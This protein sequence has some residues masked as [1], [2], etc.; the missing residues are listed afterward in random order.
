MA[1]VE[2]GVHTGPQDIEVNELRRVWRHCDGAGFDLITVWDH[3]YQSPYQNPQSPTY[4]AGALL[5]AMALDTTR[6]RIGCLCFGMGYRNPAVLAKSLTTIDHLSGG[7][8]TVGLGAGWLVEEH[9]AYGVDLLSVKERLNRLDEGVQV[10]RSL[11]NEERSSFEGKYYELNDATNYPRPLQGRVPII[12]GGG[13]E[14]RTMAIA[15][16]YGDG[17]N[18]A[19][20]SADAY[21]HKNHVLDQWCERLGRDPASLERSVLLHFRMSSR[22]VPPDGPQMDGAIFGPPGQ[23]IDQLG[24][25]VDARAQRI[26]LAIR[27]PVDWDALDTFIAEVMPA[28][29]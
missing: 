5:A 8:L 25:Y 12:V 20:M 26:S 2:L 13:G 11:L 7:R 14:Q 10:V 27:P 3:F 4:E 21:R 28:F 23:V 16:K 24:R 9:Q 15:A 19:Y 22:G 29:R 6:S 17:T 1:R 18:Q